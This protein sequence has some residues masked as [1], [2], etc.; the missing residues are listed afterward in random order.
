MSLEAPA[1]L[2][3]AIKRRDTEAVKLLLDHDPALATSRSSAGETPAIVAIYCRAG[4][5]LDL[6]RAGGVALDVFEASAAGDEGRVRELL[7]ADPSLIR[8]HASDGWTPL[9]LAAHFRHERVVE[10]L[11]ERGAD[12]NLRSLNSHANTPL[13]AALAGGAGARLVQRLIGAG[14][15]VDARQGGG[16]TGLHEAA[17]IGSEENVRLLLDAG[18]DAEAKTDEGKTP[19]VLARENGRAAIALLLAQRAR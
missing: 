1:A 9:H 11:L 15:A 13:H 12:V 18:A 16:Y 19:A 14:V 6:L 3:A 17:G 4:E 7:D 10:L 8:A 5:I 2:V